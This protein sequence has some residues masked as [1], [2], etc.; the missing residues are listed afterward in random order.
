M[1]FDAE[2]RRSGRV[3]KSIL[4]PGGETVPFKRWL[5]ES[6][7]RME[8]DWI[9]G[10]AG[11][12]VD[13]TPGEGL[14]LLDLAGRP[15]GVTICYENAYGDR[16]RRLVAAGAA[17]L[18]NLSNEAWFGTTTEFDQMELQSV[19]RAVETRRALFRSTNSGISCL[20][21]PDGHPPAGGDRL[22]VDGHDRAV[23][24]TFAAR[25]PVYTGTTPYVR[26]GDWPG[27][28]ALL[29]AAWAVWRGAGGRAAAA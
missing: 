15:Y 24:G 28:L 17:F 21:R 22:V 1:A 25:V 5:P 8:E 14:P 10:F 4:V 12:V 18:V 13:L 29:A 19:L 7:Q 6:L 11:W 26:F 9:R 27:W 3:D 16:G 2:G 23:A 20:V